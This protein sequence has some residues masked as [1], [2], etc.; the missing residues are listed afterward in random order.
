MPE[1]AGCE[2]T[3][4]LLEAVFDSDDDNTACTTFLLVDE[5]DLVDEPRPRR[6]QVD[7]AWVAA[8]VGAS[9]ALASC[10]R[11][12]EVDPVAQSVLQQL[13]DHGLDS[14]GLLGACDS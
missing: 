6:H 1:F 8:R 3:L 9:C 10:V 5:V 11:I 13:Q 2:H 7:A 4:Q 12:A 14:V